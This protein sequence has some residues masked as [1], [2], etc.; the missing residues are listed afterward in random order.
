MPG[1]RVGHVRPLSSPL[2]IE[3]SLA[4]A[5]ALGA[6]TINEPHDRKGLRG[7]NEG[8]LSRADGFCEVGIDIHGAR[9]VYGDGS[10]AHGHI[11]A[12]I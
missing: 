7:E 1:A 12:G 8:L 3:G 4:D 11:S 2:H 10:F 6:T 5:P 9:G